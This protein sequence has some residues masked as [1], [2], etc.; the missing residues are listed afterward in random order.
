MNSSDGEALSLQQLREGS[1]VMKI[2]LIAAA[3]GSLLFA[4]GPASAQVGFSA[5]PWGTGAQVGPFGFGV[6]PRYERP[7]WREG[8]R[9]RGAY[10]YAPGDCRRIRERI[11][12]PSGRVIYRVHRDCD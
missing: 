7:Y 9:D 10:A 12:T 2:L 8:Y 11:I 4:S 5:D 3:A 6:G 1:Y